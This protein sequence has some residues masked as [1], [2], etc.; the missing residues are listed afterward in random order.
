MA[1]ISL[2]WWCSS[3]AD[4]CQWMEFSCIR[5]W[6]EQIATNG[7]HSTK[8][9]RNGGIYFVN[10]FSLLTLSSSVAVHLPLPE[11]IRN[12]RATR[13]MLQ[14]TVKRNCTAKLM[15]VAHNINNSANLYDM[16]FIKVT[17]SHTSTN[18]NERMNVGNDTKK[19]LNVLD[20]MNFLRMP[21]IVKWSIARSPHSTELSVRCVNRF[22]GYMT[23]RFRPSPYMTIALRRHDINAGAFTHHFM[24]STHWL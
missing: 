17:A 10:D 2:C 5:K 18:T 11:C 8:I 24:R 13:T 20:K 21:A 14:T 19:V 6:D 9:N 23:T 3:V 22:S 15:F 16:T 7:G 4:D 12:S 1:E